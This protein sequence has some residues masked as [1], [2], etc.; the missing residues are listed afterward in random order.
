MRFENAPGKNAT[1]KCEKNVKNAKKMRKNVK[2][3]KKC[4]KTF[5]NPVGKVEL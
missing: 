3:A 5:E 2:N 1:K 4:E